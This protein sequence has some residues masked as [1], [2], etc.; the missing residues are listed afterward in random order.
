MKTKQR[1][2]LGITAAIIAVMFSL[3]A[4]PQPNDGNEPGGDPAK[5]AT[6]TATPAAGVVG[7][8][9][10]ITLATTTTGATIRYTMDGAT[11][12]ATTGTVYSDTSKP[13]IT[14]ATTIKAIAVKDGM[15]AS[16]V[17][18]AA[19]TINPAKAATPMAT[20]AA[21]VVGSGQQITLATTTTGATIRYTTDGTAPTAT[22]GTVYTDTSKPAITT[23]TT[24]KAIAVKDGMT[25]SDVLT[26]DYTIDPAKV[27]TPTAT[28][29]AG[30]VESGTAITLTCGTDGATIR[31]TTDGAAP[32]AT[33]GAVYSDTAK[34]TIT[35]A[36]TIKA[37][38]VKDGMTASDVLTAAYTLAVTYTAQADGGASASSTKIDFT[39]SAAVSG[40]IA[41]DITIGGTPGAANKGTLTQTND[42]HWSLA[43]TT[44][45]AGAATVSIARNGIE[46]GTK[47]ITL[48]KVY[49]VTFNSNGGSNVSSQTVAQS[50]TATTPTPPTKTGYGFGGWYTDNTTF[51]NA[52]NFTTAVTADITLY[53]KWTAAQYTVT[54]NYEEATGGNSDATATVIYGAPY[55]L[56]VPTKSYYT[57]GG[58]WSGPGGT[59]TQY[60]GADGASLANWNGTAN[61]TL[62]AKWTA[63]T[64]IVTYNY[65]GATGGNSNATAT[66]TYGAAYTLATPTRTGYAFGGWWSGLGGTGT[67]YTGA[68]GASLANWNGTANITLY[69]KWTPQYTVTYNYDGATGGNSSA[70]ATVTYGAPY[71]LAVPTK[72]NYAFGGWWSGLGGTGTQYTG[73]DGASLANWNGT[74][75]ITLYAKWSPGFSAL[76]SGSS[77]P[78]TY[79]TLK[80]AFEGEAGYT[81]TITMYTNADITEKFNISGSST[82][83]TLT[84]SGGSFTVSRNGSSNFRMFDITSGGKLT[85]NGPTLQGSVNDGTWD[86]NEVVS[87]K[88]NNSS[89]TLQ[90]GIITGNTANNWDSNA[91]VKVEDHATFTMTG[92]TISGNHNENG[93]GVRIG[94]AGKFIMSGGE[95]SGNTGYSSG[96]GVFITDDDSEFIMS[97][98]MIT[99]N[100]ATSN[101]GGGVRVE[102]GGTFTY[103]TGTISG[104]VAFPQWGGSS[105][106]MQV[107]K[108]SDGVINGSGGVSESAGTEA[109]YDV[110]PPQP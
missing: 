1:L 90:S 107:R 69:A 64:Y 86:D 57:F 17:L 58:W 39:F 110:W 46:S 103:N 89:F 19:Y 72:S 73:A 62:Y 45:T 26:A 75:N 61:I 55:T 70:T 94:H 85:L 28:P 14:A 54:Y 106:G 37:I 83:I 50:G 27:A 79:S 21:G 76:R 6:P 92:G 31:Y 12:T 56:A 20:P 25:N 63:N 99:G 34:P 59:G 47:S 51:A 43:I 33:T 78:T 108:D 96:G 60:T 5:A 77:T 42:T 35:A 71:T 18:T 8:G 44:T 84:Q 16:D 102:R 22:T 13:T 29:A 109:V 10:Q 97:G 9:Q 88:D 38:A 2:Q 11:P 82:N 23:A 91:G 68:D 53:A 30:A 101:G 15:T 66:V 41:N 74:A 104:N 65:D 93:G 81:A 7:S 100:T 52:Y 40:L 48:Y 95:I 4:C 32:T 87:V 105:R 67:Q 3:T 98:G 80:A 36:T 49:T 24:I